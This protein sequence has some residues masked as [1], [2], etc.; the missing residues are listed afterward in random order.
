MSMTA[1]EIEARISELTNQIRP[2]A[3]ERSQLE[4]TLREIQSPFKIGD[5]IEW[6]PGGRTGRTAK[7]RVVAIYGPYKWT[8]RRILKDGSLG[9]IC[10]VYSWNRPALVKDA[11]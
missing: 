6:R 9:T 3:S 4:K 5:V 10:A 7:G 8:A 11:P 1:T 2:L